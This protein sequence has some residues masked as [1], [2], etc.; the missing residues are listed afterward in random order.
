MRDKPPVE[1]RN[2]RS[3]R[4]PPPKG[5]A[6]PRDQRSDVTGS[7]PGRARPARDASPAAPAPGPRRAPE[8]PPARRD[9]APPR[10][11]SWLW[12]TREGAESD[13]A[14]ELYLAGDRAA[15]IAAPSVVIS[16]RAPR[17]S[18]RI[19]LTFARQGFQ[20]GRVVTAN[21]P[22]E[23]GELAAQALAERLGSAPR[24]V[25]HVWVP[26]SQ[27]ANT[28]APLA[29][30]LEESVAE[31]LAESL[32]TSERVDARDIGAAA[33]PMAQLCLLSERVAVAGILP[34]DRALSLAPGGR[35]RAKVGGDRPSRAAR[36]LAEAFAW[37]GVAP[38]P[39]ELCVDLGAAPGGWTWVLAER[40]ARV[41]AVDPGR[42]RPDLLGRRGV[43][44]VAGSAFDFA[45]D[46]P[47]DWLFCDMV[48]RPLEVA[49]LLG[50]W[51]RRRM[52]T[53]LVANFKLPMRRKAEMVRDIVAILETGGWRAVRA[54]RL[55]H[56]RDEVTITA[57][58]V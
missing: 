12:T 19:E 51:G 49:R 23:V 10:P 21:S 53:L 32:P 18:G 29:R 7:A 45:P 9:S 16:E 56:D 30:S 36:K 48:F 31:H 57:R 8:L 28:L 39:G 40:R 38:E 5:R 24:H 42:L 4:G 11:G 17:P 43:T 33:T 47:V 14:D 55:Y 6:K 44:Y 26:D 27:A 34:S 54:R 58:L 20:G 46:E 35:L 50:K 52:A 22:T 41:I 13:L 37:L 1:R 15:R 25:L 2:R 3:H